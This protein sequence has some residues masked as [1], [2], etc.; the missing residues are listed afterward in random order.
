MYT[1]INLLKKA[2]SLDAYG[3]LT[4]TYTKRQVYA[5]DMS[6]SMT[7]VYQAMA[8][9]YKPEVKF[10]LENFCDYQGEELV[11]YCPFNSQDTYIL[12]VLRTF[13][14]GDQLEIV[15]YAANDHPKVV[16]QNGGT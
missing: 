12:R 7:E 15:C 10:R 6:V 3:D 16:E 11:E 9:G 4:E 14:V 1:A 5:E 13:R 2:Q 8:V